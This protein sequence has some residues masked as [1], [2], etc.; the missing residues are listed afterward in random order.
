MNELSFGKRASDDKRTRGANFTS[1]DFSI[2]YLD[3]NDRIVIIIGE[4]KYTESYGKEY[5]RFSKSKSK[6][7]RYSKV[8]A[9]FLN[10]PN[11]NI[12]IPNAAT[13]DDLFYDPIDQLMRLQLLA[14]EMEYNK[15]MNADLVDVLLIVPEKNREFID[16]VHSNN[17]KNIL[18]NNILNVW[19]GIVQNNKFKYVYSEDLLRNII[20]VINDKKISEYLSLR[21]Q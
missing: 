12:K 17:L 11:C 16:N 18:G 19:S 5:K 8:Y 4:W 20:S 6:T 14:Q 7:D 1:A 21:Y 10:Q 15:E 13:Y 9:K 2:R 3:S